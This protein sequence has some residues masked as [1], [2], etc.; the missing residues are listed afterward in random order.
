MS[1]T[2]LVLTDDASDTALQP[3]LQAETS[4]IK[5]LRLAEVEPLWKKHKVELRVSEDRTGHYCDAVQEAL[6]NLVRVLPRRTLTPA[7]REMIMLQVEFWVRRVDAMKHGLR[8]YR[9]YGTKH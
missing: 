9:F 3:W 7:A 8:F 1:W 2:D 5:P 4:G 6:A